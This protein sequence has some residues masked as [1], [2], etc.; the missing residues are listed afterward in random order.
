MKKTISLGW[1]YRISMY[2]FY[3][4]QTTKVWWASVI[5]QI[6][7]TK[8]GGTAPWVM[9]CGGRRTGQRVVKAC[10]GS[11]HLQRQRHDRERPTA[12]ARAHTGNGRRPA[13]VP[14]PRTYARRR[15]PPATVRRPRT[16]TWE[17]RP[18][19]ETTRSSLVARS[20]SSRVDESSAVSRLLLSRLSR[21]TDGRCVRVRASAS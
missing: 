6:Q 7:L 17:D 14:R 4:G 20:L 1:M 19:V 13:K 18:D 12:R 21:V 15:R 10:C 5:G 9:Y 8:L 3:G 11:Q 16:R 2:V